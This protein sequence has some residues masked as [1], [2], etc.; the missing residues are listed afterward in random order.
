MNIPIFIPHYGCPNGCVF[1]NQKR[2]SGKESLDDEKAIRDLI[3]SSLKTAGNRQKVEIAFFGGSFTG[4]EKSIQEKYLNIASEYVT[5]YRLE[6]IRISTRPDY[7]NENCMRFLSKYPVTAIELGVQSLDE[8]VLKKTKRNHSIKDVDT[9]VSYIKNSSASLGLQMMIGLPGD[10]F[11]KAKES[12]QKIIRYEPDTLRIYPTLVLPDT[13]L[14]DMYQAGDYVPLSLEDAVEWT[15]KLLPL[16]IEKNIQILRV[17]LQASEGLNEEHIIIGPYHPAFKEL[18]LDKMVY[19]SLSRQLIQFW[20]TKQNGYINE[21]ESKDY[22]VELNYVSAYTN[23]EKVSVSIHSNTITLKSSLSMKQRLIG[24]K[25]QNSERF[26]LFFRQ[27]LQR[28]VVV[29]IIN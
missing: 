10:T 20:D 27:L 19:D 14:C 22:Y 12:S 1:C 11:L 29:F 17:G 7:I 13:E 4:L 9:A 5:K 3:E 23:V 28:E 25:R 24:H 8:D 18:V 26:T 21:V 15:S 6:G 2:I 16:F